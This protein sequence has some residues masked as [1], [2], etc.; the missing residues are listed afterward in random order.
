MF[1]WTLH[2]GR[3]LKTP[4]I[5]I[6]PGVCAVSFVLVL[7]ENLV[8]IFLHNLWQ[9]VAECVH[10]CPRLNLITGRCSTI[11]VPRS[12]YCMAGELVGALVEPECVCVRAFVYA[13][14]SMPIG[15][16][17]MFNASRVTFRSHFSM[18]YVRI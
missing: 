18:N 12:H 7:G 15:W 1:R 4:S 17:G 6:H 11:F 3:Y 16:F 8:D 14:W 10:I 5:D 13:M 2:F 9:D